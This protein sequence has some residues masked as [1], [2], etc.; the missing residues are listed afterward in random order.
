MS[1]KAE[2]R[3]RVSVCVPVPVYAE[4]QNSLVYRRGLFL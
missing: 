4:K 3:E 2:H 1:T